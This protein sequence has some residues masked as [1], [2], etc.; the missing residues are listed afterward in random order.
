MPE[1]GEV[2]RHDGPDYRERFGEGLWPSHRRA[3]DDLI[4][5]RTEALGGHLLQC[6]PCGQA[7]YAYHSYRHRSCPKCHS[8]DTAGW[9]AEWRQELLPVPY[10]HVV[11]TLPQALHE[12]V[13][14]HQN[15]LDAI[16]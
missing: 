4:H 7:H 11:L 15:D 16:L 3:M 5:C 14:R 9:L 1:V 10:F 13:R 6:E 2:L 8:Y 12:L